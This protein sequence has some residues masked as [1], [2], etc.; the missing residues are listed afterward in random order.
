MGFADAD[1]KAIQNVPK[2]MPKSQYSD[3]KIGDW[4][5]SPNNLDSFMCCLL[6]GADGTGKSGLVLDYLTPED[7]KEGKKAVIIDLDGVAE[8]FGR[9]GEIGR[10]ICHG[11]GLA[12]ELSLPPIPVSSDP[13]FPPDIEFSSA[14]DP[15]EAQA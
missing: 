2:E 8:G 7:V 10:M 15:A 11:E 4:L 9:S 1:E 13:I 6:L 12:G 3:E 5:M 14:S